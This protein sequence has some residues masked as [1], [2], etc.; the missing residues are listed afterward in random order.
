MALGQSWTHVQTN[1]RNV[2]TGTNALA[3]A[4]AATAGHLIVV[5]VDWSDGSS[6]SS[7]GDSQGD[8]FTQVGTEQYSVRIG[9]R[10][11][12]YYAANIHGGLTT[13]TTR[14]TGSP[15]FHEL[16]IHEYAGLD[17]VSPLDA[18]AVQLA[19]GT[20]FT[21]ASAWFWAASLGSSSGPWRAVTL[22]EAM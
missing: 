7:I 9:V 13:I 16:Y 21:D 3:F 14:V 8:V 18:F 1:A 10:S 15:Q 17:A 22:V 19:D 12:L 6:F 5:E 11:R 20:S 4:A 2:A